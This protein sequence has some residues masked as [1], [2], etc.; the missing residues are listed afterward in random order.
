MKY[1]TKC[2]NQL[3]DGML[4]CQKCGEKIIVATE[5]IHIE[6]GCE[7]A[8]SQCVKLRTSMKV[9]MIIFFVF[10][11]IFAIGATSDASMLAGVFAF[12]VLGLMFLILAKTQKGNFKVLSNIS[13][14]RKTQGI[15]K[16][17]FVCTS[18]FLSLFLFVGIINSF[19]AEEIK[20]E[21]VVETD[22][23]SNT[24]I[25]P[26]EKKEK[27]E[28]INEF[29]GECPITVSASMYD[30]IIGFPELSCYIKNK[31]NKEISAIQFYFVPRDVYGEELR[32]IFAQN[33]LQMDLGISANGSDTAAWQLLEDNI[34]SG[35]VY[36]YSV[37]F[38]DGTEWGNRNAAVSE[39]K[40]SALKV[41]ASY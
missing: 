15:T 13:C 16:S 34:K 33:R 19:E 20:T 21:T 10:T 3:T 37:Y 23:V 12:G 4:F 24:D 2:G 8:Q 41:H 39:I 7:H 14:F 6:N 11:A 29:S 22:V 9:W 25:T 30:N 36:I 38:S 32:G 35:D 18:V 28:E 27:K 17:V 26:E 1:C 31:T 5:R 40:K